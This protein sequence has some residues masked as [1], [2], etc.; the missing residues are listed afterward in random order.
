MR[1]KVAQEAAAGRFAG[2]IAITQSG[3]TMFKGAYGF[4]DRAPDEKRRETRAR[5][6]L[7]ATRLFRD[8]GFEQTTVDEV[9][10]AAG[11]SRRTFFLHFATKEEDAVL[12]Q[13]DDFER[14]LAAAVRAA[15]PGK[16]VLELAEHAVRVT[17]EQFDPEDARM[18]E[19]LMRATPVLRARSQGKQEWLERTIATALDERHGALSGDLGRRV[20]ALLIAAV[21]RVA[22]E[23][24]VAAA[25]VGV[26]TA[27]HVRRVVATF[28][29]SLP[30][31]QD[32]RETGPSSPQGDL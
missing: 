22:L 25:T 14:V 17:L 21:L 32:I 12:S 1:E 15:P 19:Q 9:A 29:R 27:E 11:V 23:G 7:A 3:R 5:L 18:N 26:M 16:T 6:M 4:A 31:P 28:E 24:W 2:A 8:Q 20:D 13:H 10:A 30:V